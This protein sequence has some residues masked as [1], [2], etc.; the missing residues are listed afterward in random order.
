MN[1]WQALK[2]IVRDQFTHSGP[3]YA[4][5]FYVVNTRAKSIV[6][7]E[8][9]VTEEDALAYIDVWRKRGEIVDYLDIYIGAR[10]L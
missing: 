1:T 3:K 10:V 8:P 5:G 9:F 2:K 6:R 4:V 7:R